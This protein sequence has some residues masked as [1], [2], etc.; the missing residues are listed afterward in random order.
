MSHVAKL[1]QQQ[2]FLPPQ[3]VTDFTRKT[4]AA[5]Y[6]DV[7]FPQALAALDYLRDLEGRRRKEIRESLERLHIQ[8][9][10]AT[11]GANWNDYINE[12]QPNLGVWLDKMLRMEWK[13]DVIYSQI[14][15]TLR[16]WVSVGVI[17][18]F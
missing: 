1:P 5:R 4:F 11:S 6:D 15:A 9:A 13:V 18:H 7:V 3:F 14:Y 2:S 10:A 16:S 12:L 8:P 17:S